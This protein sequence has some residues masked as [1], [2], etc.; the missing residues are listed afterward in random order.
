M[1]YISVLDV[2]RVT[3]KY[4]FLVANFGF[5]EFYFPSILFLRNANFPILVASFSQT[6]AFPPFISKAFSRSRSAPLYSF[7]SVGF[8]GL[9]GIFTYG[10]KAYLKTSSFLVFSFVT[11]LSYV[12]LFLSYSFLVLSYF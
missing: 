10:S 7:T 9:S 11:S 8:C 3:F 6:L 1:I 5:G 4:P 2:S 12:I